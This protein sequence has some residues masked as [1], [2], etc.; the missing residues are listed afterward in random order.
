MTVATTTLQATFVSESAAYESTFGWYNKVTG[1]GG[2]LFADVEA[3][4]NNAPLVAGVSSVNFTV[5]TADLGNIEFFLISDGYNRNSGDD[6]TGGIKVIRLSDGSWAVANV[7]SQGRVITRNGNPD[8]LSGAGADALFTEKSKNE[9]NVDYASSVAGSTQTAATLAGDTADGL[10]GL[11]AWEDLAATRNKNGTYSKPGDAD[12]NDAVFRI[13]TANGNQA[14]VAN[15]DTATV[16]ENAGATTINVLGNDTDP[17]SGDTLRV[18]SVNTAGLFGTVTIVGANDAAVIGAATLVNVTE[19]VGTNGSGN[20]TASGTIS[21][22]DVDQGQSSFQT[23]VTGSA[24]NLGSLILATNGAYTYSVANAAA[25]SL[26]AG[27]AKV[28]TFTITALDGT[29][30]QISFTIHGANDLSLIHI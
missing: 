13:T 1:Y 19:D 26:G 11:L 25:Q 22:S 17:N 24:G 14:P 29:T 30:Q 3:E 21:I 4:G 15:A 9:G 27:Q 12:Y 10:T 16:S 20:L 5:N 8:I 28:D 18:Q 7:D 23:G 6:F 2:I